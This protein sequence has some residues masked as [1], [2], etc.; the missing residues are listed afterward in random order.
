[1]RIIAGEKKGRIIFS[2]PKSMFVKPIS[3]RIRQSLFDILRPRVPGSIFLDL[4]AGV[5]TVGLEAL[6]RGSRNAV[7][8]EKEGICV[9][10]IEK[11]IKHLDF[12]SKARVLKADVMSGLEWLKH[13]SMYEGYDI[14]FL[15]PPY[16]D[17]NNIPLEYGSKTLELI[18]V[19]DLFAPDGIAVLQQRGHHPEFF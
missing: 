15:G 14:I 2:V 18:S 3:S 1:M 11:N 4:Y 13:F 5:G 9:K 17:E 8:V 10:I 16:R 12:S 19:S 7:F 6:S